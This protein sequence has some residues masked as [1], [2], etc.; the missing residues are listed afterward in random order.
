MDV[1]PWRVGERPVR[2]RSLR[3]RD[4]THVGRHQAGADLTADLA[5]GPHRPEKFE[6]FPAFSVAD[7]VSRG[8]SPIA[9]VFYVMAYVNLFVA[10]GVLVVLSLWRWG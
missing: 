3:W 10:L 7:A 4:G 8:G 9:R 5:G 1:V 6:R 2:C